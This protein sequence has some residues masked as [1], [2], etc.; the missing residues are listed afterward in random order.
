ME[1][2]TEDIKKKTVKNTAKGT[3]KE[4]NKKIYK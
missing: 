1:T 2:A 3:K 4:N